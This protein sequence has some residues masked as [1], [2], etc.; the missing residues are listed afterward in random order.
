MR[1]KRQNY[2]V[3]LKT[4]VTIEALKEQKNISEEEVAKLF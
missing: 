3:E 4:K 2:S 1:K